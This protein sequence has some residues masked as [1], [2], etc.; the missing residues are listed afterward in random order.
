MSKLIAEQFFGHPISGYVL[1]MQ[2]TQRQFSSDFCYLLAVDGET[3]A[4]L[5][6]DFV[7]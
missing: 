3:V 4:W 6:R 1:I 2:D 7:Q 5:H